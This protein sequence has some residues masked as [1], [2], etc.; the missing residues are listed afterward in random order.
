MLLLA[1]R[2]GA[3]GRLKLFDGDRS[4]ELYL[5]E[6]S[7]HQVHGIDDLV[8]A[9]D[10]DLPSEGDMVRLVNLAIEAGHPAQQV[11][12]QVSRVLGAAL[13][14]WSLAEI[15][16]LSFRPGELSTSGSLRLP[17]SLISMLGHGLYL[18]GSPH[19]SQKLLDKQGVDPVAV[20]LPSSFQQQPV[21]LDALS[22]RVIGIA[23]QRPSLQ[24]LVMRAIGSNHS[25]RREV[26]HR[27][28]L[29]YTLGVLHLPE[30][31]AATAK[32]RRRKAP[33]RERTRKR[34][35]REPIQRRSPRPRP[36]ST[37]QRVARLRKRAKSILEKN[38]YARL[39]FADA[40]ERPVIEK[41]DEAY[42]RLSRR[43]HPDSLTD[44]PA[45]VREISKDIFASL[46][47]AIEGLRRKR[48]ADEHWERNRCAQQGV[49]YVTDRDRT[50]AKVSFK[51][52]ERLFRNKEYDIAEA[53]FHEAVNRDPLTPEYGLKHAYSAFLARQMTPEEATRIIDALEP[54]ND[55]QASRFQYTVGRILQLSGAGNDKFL[56]RF[57]A[58]VNRDADNRDAQ[59]ELRLHDMRSER[60]G[61]A[62]PTLGSFLDR[63]RRK[64][65]NGSD[66]T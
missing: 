37:E 11:Q 33:P 42:R 61:A 3:T 20:L 4:H 8:T 27:V 31:S 29:L 5:L 35:P 13:A 7:I 46:S 62:S 40:T 21:G 12:E 25:R 36:V 53:C 2:T 24:D 66:P 65:K 58:A 57:Q 39:G 38:Y 16:L 22:T 23:R 47:E 32:Q 15:G 10:S 18:Q 64:A 34:R 50:K 48:T 41:A 6:G 30:V 44:A 9:L 26:M 63:F 56:T 17:R 43:Y 55:K 49:P 19:R 60:P 28:F 45:A 14:E 51:K 1:Q 59:R 52:G 54:E